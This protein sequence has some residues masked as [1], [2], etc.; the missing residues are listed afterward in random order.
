MSAP[1]LE[2]MTASEFFKMAAIPDQKHA[3]NN[4]FDV[5]GPGDLVSNYLVEAVITIDIE[6]NSTV[7]W[8]FFS[9]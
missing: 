8:D 6:F 3:Y 9:P 1:D 7:C 2:K 5:R 4:L